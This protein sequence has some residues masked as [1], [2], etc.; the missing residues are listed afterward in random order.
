ML[1]FTQN[2]RAILHVYHQG[3]F[4]GSESSFNTD[5]ESMNKSNIL[6]QNQIM[7]KQVIT[8]FGL[9]IT[10]A[11]GLILTSCDTNP[12]TEQSP[13][14]S[15]TP[16]E[17]AE[18]VSEIPEEQPQPISDPPACEDGCQ[19]LST[20]TSLSKSSIQ[21]E[22]FA[23][24]PK[25]NNICEKTNQD[26]YCSILKPYQFADGIVY[27]KVSGTESFITDIQFISSVEQDKAM[28]IAKAALNS[29]QPFEK[30]EKT[31]DKIILRSN[32]CDQGDDTYYLEETYLNLNSQNQVTQITSYS[33]T[34]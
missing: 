15:D 12:Q 8:K 4:T 5:N 9:F 25:W 30:T 11:F 34:P 14:N 10:L 22:V 20:D 18:P 2:F 16:T 17:Q 7:K 28:S 31:K 32:P 3:T 29:Q 26:S 13:S 1:Y 6:L 27:L 24:L 23:N 19:K 33:T 21:P